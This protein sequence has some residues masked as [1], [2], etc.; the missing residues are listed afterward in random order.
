M[1]YTYDETKPF[2]EIDVNEVLEELEAPDN[3][4]V[5]YEVWATGYTADDKCTDADFFIKEFADPDEAVAYAKELTLADVV[6]L[7]SDGKAPVDDIAYLM[8]EV[9]TVVEYEDDIG[10]TTNVGTIYYKPILIK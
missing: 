3:S 8:I 6:H 10:C 1:T 5:T 9:E 7:T 4:A 2:E